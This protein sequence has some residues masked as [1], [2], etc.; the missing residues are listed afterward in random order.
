MSDFFFF[1]HEKKYDKYF[2]VNHNLLNTIFNL[3]TKDDISNP[4]LHKTRKINF[5]IIIY[6]SIRHDVKII[7]FTVKAFILCCIIEVRQMLVRN[8]SMLYLTKYLFNH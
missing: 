2:F 1:Y 8:F 3:E 6:S 7:L 4:F 5:L